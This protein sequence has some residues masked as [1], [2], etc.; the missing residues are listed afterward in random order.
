MRRF[1]LPAAIAAALIVPFSTA[2]QQMAAGDMRATAV[3]S[4]EWAPLE[5]EGFAPGLALAVIHGDPAAPDKPYTLR[6]R[7]PDG[8]A[9]PA[10]WHPNAENLTVLSGTFLLSMEGEQAGPLETYHPGDYLYIPGGMAHSGRVQGETIVQLHGMGPFEVRLGRNL[11]GA[12][13]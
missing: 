3:A 5:L 2:A 6:L 10:H 12:N 4:L 7:F 11:V 8:Y 1:I 13:R 9:F